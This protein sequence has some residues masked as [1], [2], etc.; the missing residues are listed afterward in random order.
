ML[1]GKL[2]C[3]VLKIFEKAFKLASHLV[4]LG[5]H[6]E[7]DLDARKVDAEFA[8]ERKYDLKPLEVRIFVKPCIPD[9]PRRQQ[10]P[11]ALIEPKSLRVDVIQLRHRTDSV[12]FDSL[13]HSSST[14]RHEIK[15]NG[16]DS[17]DIRVAISG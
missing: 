9:R 10:K 12:S 13:L 6:I 8:R 4:H 2:V 5:T 14:Q 1:G 3:V 7:N 15:Q 11:F 17:Q 16:Q